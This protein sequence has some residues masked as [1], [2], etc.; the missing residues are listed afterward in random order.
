[1]KT[2]Y[3]LT[4]LCVITILISCNAQPKQTAEFFIKYKANNVPYQILF[5][6]VNESGYD[7][8]SD[9]TSVNRKFE[10]MTD[11]VIIN[12]GQADFRFEFYKRNNRSNYKTIVFTIEKNF[13][14]SPKEYLI[15][16]FD[17]DKPI[18]AEKRNNGY[19]GLAGF[20]IQKGN[21]LSWQYSWTKNRRP[22]KWTITKV[23]TVT[24][25]ISGTF[26]FTT[27][28]AE[29]DGNTDQAKRD[30]FKKV[31]EVDLTDGEFHLPY[32]LVN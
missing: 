7:N 21:L 3:I 31:V 6:G 25:T 8:L 20:N 24:K 17:L 19:D 30:S 32:K 22:A 10:Q 14:T 4:L 16:D 13:N 28:L 11:S 27:T 15:A 12:G 29:G 2:K 23:D 26:S 18:S 5:S 9:S 1:M